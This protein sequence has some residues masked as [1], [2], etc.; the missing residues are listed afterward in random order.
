M[1]IKLFSA[2]CYLDNTSIDVKDNGNLIYN[3][4]NET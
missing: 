3:R 1:R 2:M 4:F